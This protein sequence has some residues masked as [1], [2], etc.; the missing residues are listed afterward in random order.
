MWEIF[1][2][3]FNVNLKLFLRLFNCASVGEKNFDNLKIILIEMEFDLSACTSKKLH[4]LLT[5][6]DFLIMPTELFAQ[7]FNNE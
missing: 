7:C 4:I 2:A 5:N 6:I 1:N 3:N